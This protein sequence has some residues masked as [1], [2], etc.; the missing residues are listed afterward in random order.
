M[1]DGGK[2]LYSRVAGLSCNN[3]DRL[4]SIA[5]GEISVMCIAL[6]TTIIREHTVADGT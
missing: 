2:Y 4:H 6:V 1:E 5:A 3:A